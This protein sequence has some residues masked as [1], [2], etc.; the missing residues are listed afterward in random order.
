MKE[1]APYR[2]WA[3]RSGENIIDA[4][5]MARFRFVRIT[6]G[7]SL[8]YS[9][10]PPEVPA[11]EIGPEELGTLTE[12]DRRWLEDCVGTLVLE[13]AREHEAEVLAELSIRVERLERALE[14]ELRREAEGKGEGRDIQ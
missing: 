2:L 9:K 3:A 1:S 13:A 4:L 7:Y 5:A 12:D 10:T 6:P 14:M 11:V 8:V